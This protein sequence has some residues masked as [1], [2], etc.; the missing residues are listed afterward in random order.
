M[1]TLLKFFNRVDW[2]MATACFIFGFYFSE[3]WLFL[4]GAIST[5]TA[6][7]KP[8]ERIK[9]KIEKRFLRKKTVHSDNNKL[10]SEDEFYKSMGVTETGEDESAQAQAPVAL[11]YS[12]TY[13]QSGP[14]R[15][16]ISRHNALSPTNLGTSTLKQEGPQWR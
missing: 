12:A 10:A 4:A 9:A 16:H 6:W 7:Y 8:A 13:L 14:L 3:P 15:L 11:T 2:L 1:D 5:F